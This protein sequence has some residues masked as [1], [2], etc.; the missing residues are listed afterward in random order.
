[1]SKQACS[2]TKCP[3]SCAVCEEHTCDHCGYEHLTEEHA[4]FSHLKAWCR[5]CYVT[6]SERN[7]AR[8]AAALE[9]LS[10]MQDLEPWTLTQRDALIKAI[11]AAL[12]GETP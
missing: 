12:K 9:L 10:V 7:E 3:G 1:M 6:V 11:R 5:G 4:V 8:I 2:F